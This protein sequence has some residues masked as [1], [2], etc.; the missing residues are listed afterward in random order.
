MKHLFFLGVILFLLTGCIG[1]GRYTT[2]VE[3]GLNNRPTIDTALSR[4]Y[5]S[6]K[7]DG[8]KPL[9]ELKVEKI[10]SGCIP[11]L[12][13]W[14]FNHEL[15]SEYD[16]YMQVKRFN[17][18]LI[19]YCD[20]VNF[21]SRL[22]GKKLE[23]NV[24]SIPNSF[25]YSLKSQSVILIFS[26]II[27]GHEG[28]IPAPQNLAVKFKVYQNGNIYRE[29]T[30]TGKGLEEF[31]NMGFMSYQSMVNAYFK[32]NDESLKKMAQLVVKYIDSGI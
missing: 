2:I 5:L 12:L 28:I 17:S 7:S 4:S 19:E 29:G 27:M 14:E 18:Y 21:A 13:Y 15:R 10:K 3:K 23:I 31:V 22:N 26:Y 32:Q 11:A 8:I 30:Y 1:V 25:S 9:K 24:E 6:V 16:P 20:S